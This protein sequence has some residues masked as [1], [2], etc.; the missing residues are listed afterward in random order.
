M[1]RQQLVAQAYIGRV[2]VVGDCYCFGAVLDRRPPT[3]KNIPIY[4]SVAGPAA[5]VEAVWARLSQGKETSIVPADTARSAIYLEPYKAR[6]Y[7][8]SHAK[9]QELGI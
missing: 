6:V 8:R 1:N 2:N 9:I 3:Y 7:T 5:S 4:L